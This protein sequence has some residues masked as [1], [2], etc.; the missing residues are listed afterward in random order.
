MINVRLATEEDKD[1]W[2]RV[3]FESPEATYAHTWEWKEVIEDKLG[4]ES[5][6]LVAERKNEIVGIFP[7]FLRAV[8]S[9]NY[10]FNHFLNNFKIAWSPLDLTWDYGGPCALPNEDV[11]EELILGMEDIA[12]RLGVI[13]IKVSIFDDNKI[14][15]HMSKYNY[16]KST[17]HTFVLDLSVDD[18]QLWG[19]VSK[20]AR[21]YVNAAKNNN[22]TIKRVV[23]DS[24]LKKVYDCMLHT[25]QRVGAYL[26][27]LDFFMELNRKFGNKNI[28]LFRA[29]LIEDEVIG[30]DVLFCFNNMVVERYRGIY[31]EYLN[32]RT[33][34]L[35]VWTAIEESKVEGYGKYDLGG[36]STESK[37]IYFF[38]SLWGG[39][40]INT[41]WYSKD[42][43]FRKIR[44][45]NRKVF[46]CLK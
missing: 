2:N 33:N 37:G 38:K 44:A 4:L 25:H 46:R 12:K 6:C 41:D 9:N 40:L 43:K 35:M 36:V 16:K 18:K 7:V 1:G 34:Y 11:V 29:A 27:P 21:K 17:R 20:R 26:P 23:K 22:I 39:E 30:G 15:K 5:I 19:K 14:N 8:E 28:V 42:I 3:A 10:F 24:D 31:E 45:L 13:S 32:L